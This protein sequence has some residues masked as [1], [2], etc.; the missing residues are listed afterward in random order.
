MEAC[1]QD[2]AWGSHGELGSC[3]STSNG[4]TQGS[5]FWLP[6]P[7]AGWTRPPGPHAHCLDGCASHSAALSP[8]VLPLGTGTRLPPAPAPHLGAAGGGQSSPCPSQHSPYGFSSRLRSEKPNSCLAWLPAAQGRCRG[9]PR[10]WQQETNG[11]GVSGINVPVV[12]LI[13]PLPYPGEQR[14]GSTSPSG[15]MMIPIYL[16]WHL[17]SGSIFNSVSPFSPLFVFLDLDPIKICLVGCFVEPGN[18][19]QR[20]GISGIS[21]LKVCPDSERVNPLLFLSYSCC[22]LQFL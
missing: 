16:V 9:R 19:R 5:Q 14:C 10:A 17:S 1:I 22:I 21:L 11:P 15:G 12:A 13:L 2:T 7:L 20:R 6:P 3:S 8:P 18:G 4:P